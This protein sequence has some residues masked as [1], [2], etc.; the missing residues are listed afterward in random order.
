[1][2]S[3]GLARLFRRQG[4]RVAA[5]KKGPDF[6]DAAWLGRAAGS[7]G[8]NLD[9]YMMPESAIRNSLCRASENSDIAII[10]GNRGLFDG[11]DSEGAHS[12]ARLS[13]ICATPVVL[14]IDVTKATRTVAALVLGCLTMEK[15]LN[16]AGVILNRVGTL[17]QETVIRESIEKVCGIPVLGAVYRIAAQHLPSRH[18]GLVTAM[19]HPDNERSIDRVADILGRQ[20]D[21]R[22]I[23][24]I[25][26]QAAPLAVCEPEPG[27]RAK[28]PLARVGVL[29]DRA[30]TFYYPWNLTALEL[31][32][33][34]ILPIS[35]LADEDLP[36]IDVLYAGG[37]FPEVYAAELS[38]NHGMR[39]K[40]A[41]LIEHGLPVW[42]E[43]GGLMY[44]SRAL[45]KNGTAFPMVGALPFTVE[46][47]D[48]PQGHGYTEAVVDG[49]N[50]FLPEGTRLLGHEFHYSRIIEGDGLDG[51]R[52]VMRLD[53]GCGIAG[54]RDGVAVGNVVATYSHLHAS[55]APDWAPGLVNSANRLNASR[56]AGGMQ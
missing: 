16:L 34:E 56:H 50:P 30:F 53:R 43:C 41:N 33:A 47:T 49:E 2:V 21:T 51:C 20:L 3:I 9:T 5:F 36:E 54:G 17:R 44:L 42:A 29:R 13:G 1:M 39:C 26:R 45:V 10:E 7:A 25:S 46:H 6:I 38:A 52:T 22:A 15:D 35:P 23:L 19:E 40:L 11:F 31:A 27:L 24:E 37:G 28:T 12:T 48:R 32:G 55:G 14:V 4:L 18:L 8:C